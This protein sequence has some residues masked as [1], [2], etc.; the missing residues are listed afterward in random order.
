MIFTCRK[1]EFSPLSDTPQKEI[2]CDG[3][4]VIV[5]NFHQRKEKLD[6]QSL[7]K[8]KVKIENARSRYSDRTF[9]LVYEHYFKAICS[10]NNNMVN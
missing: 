9:S 6:Q 7:S 8:K 4:L 5:E 3:G 10:L 1:I 2:C